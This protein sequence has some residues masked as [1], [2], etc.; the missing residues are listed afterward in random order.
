MEIMLNCLLF[1]LF[2]VICYLLVYRWYIRKLVDKFQKRNN[3]Q[4]FAKE[5]SFKKL[6]SKFNL[7]KTKENFLFLQGYPLNLNAISYYM[8]KF[9]MAG[10]FGLAGMLNYHSYLA[11]LLLGMIGYFFIDFYIRIH[12]K[13]RDNEI[14]SDLLTVTNA[15][16]MQLSAYVPLKDSLKKQYENCHNKD[17]KKAIMMFATKYELS[18]LNI[19]DALNDLKTRFDILELDMFCNTIRQYNK[20]GNIIELL[21]NLS[22]ILKEKYVHQL[23]E[24]TREKVLYIT[25]GVIVALG[26]IVLI[27]FYPLFVSIGN[28]F[29]QIFK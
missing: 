2:F 26:N 25:L 18:E 24:K 21:D 17:F 10:L 11:M 28:N 13:T 20:V 4:D 15:I 12:K 27:T 3:I 9:V 19:E 29:N 23:K 22:T 6:F 5:N 8:V 16:T 1:V 7:I 14:C